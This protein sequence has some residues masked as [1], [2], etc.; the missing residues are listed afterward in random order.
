MSAKVFIIY[1][2]LGTGT[3]VTTEP[4]PWSKENAG[5][6]PTFNFIDT[7]PTTNQIVTFLQTNFG[8]IPSPFN[9][10]DIKLF[11]N[12]DPNLII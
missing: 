11:Y 5:Y 10:N 1:Y 6:F 3:F 4:R 12:F 7:F 8:F 2:K 9:N